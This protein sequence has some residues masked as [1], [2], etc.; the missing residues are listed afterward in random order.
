MTSIDDDVGRFA[1]SVFLVSRTGV[2]AQYVPAVRPTASAPSKEATVFS[3]IRTEAAEAE[4]PNEKN[5]PN[6]K[7]ERYSRGKAR[8]AEEPRGKVHGVES[9]GIFS[10]AYR[11]SGECAWKQR[12]FS[13]LYAR[14]RRFASVYALLR[15]AYEGFSSM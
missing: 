11:L 12:R 4:V 15:S 8:R 14:L 1:S 13:E 2:S 7:V 10:E 5:F 9:M 6:I 3:R